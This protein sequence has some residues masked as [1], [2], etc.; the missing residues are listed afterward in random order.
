MDQLSGTFH[1]ARDAH[2]HT[3]FHSRAANQD[4]KY[5]LTTNTQ[6]E[7]KAHKRG[8]SSSIRT[9]ALQHKPQ[10]KSTQTDLATTTRTHAHNRLRTYGLPNKKIR[11][12]TR[13]RTHSVNTSGYTVDTSGS[14]PTCVHIDISTDTLT[15]RHIQTHKPNTGSRKHNPNAAPKRQRTTKKTIFRVPRAEN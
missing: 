12:N 10:T 3:R 8:R 7:A 6:F 14:E 2:T 15:H 1:R 9:A 11:P 5:I 13:S 4:G